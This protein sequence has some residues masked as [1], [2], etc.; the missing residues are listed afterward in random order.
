MRRHLVIN[1]LPQTME[2][3][4]NTPYLNFI[5][6]FIIAGPWFEMN[7]NVHQ[8]IRVNDVIL[9]MCKQLHVQWTLL[10]THI[11]SSASCAHNELSSLLLSAAVPP[12][13]CLGAPAYF[14]QIKD[15][16]LPLPSHYSARS[17]AAGGQE[18]LAPEDATFLQLNLQ[19]FREKAS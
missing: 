10:T 18:H 19:G 7:S 8:T 5:S 12:C 3:E 2:M 11:P 14:Q 6:S 9:K 17:T 16:R 4:H 13:C 15:S 1:R